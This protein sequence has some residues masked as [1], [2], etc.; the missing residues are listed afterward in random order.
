MEVDSQPAPKRQKFSRN[1]KRNW[2]KIDITET[3]EFLEQKRFEER[4]FGK[5]LEEAKDDELFVIDKKGTPKKKPEKSKFFAHE[6]RWLWESWPLGFSPYPISR[7]FF[8]P[9][10]PK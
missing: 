5:T 10:N 3:E 4:K 6:H 7:D 2:G 1:K 8:S 9:K